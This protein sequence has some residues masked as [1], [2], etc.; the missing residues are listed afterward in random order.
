MSADGKRP[1][2]MSP[3]VAVGLVLV[4]AFSLIA[5]LV[6]S[7]YAPDLRSDTSGGANALSKSAI[8]FA[9]LRV[10]LENG[11]VPATLGRT[12]PP[13]DTFGLVI[14][15]PEIDTPQKDL[16]AL[17]QPGA[18]LIVLPKW[19]AANQPLHSGWV[20]KIGPWN[21]SELAQLMTPLV[22]HAK[23]RQSGKTAPVRLMPLYPRFGSIA[24]RTPV[25]IDSVQTIS[26]D[27]LD[28]DIVDGKGNAVLAQIK[29]TQ[30]YILAD[31]DLMNDHGLADVATA[32]FAYDLVQL[33]RVGDR[34]VSFDVTLNGFGQSPSLLRTVFS[35]PFLGA[36]LCAILAAAF[37]AFHAF[38]RFGG[39]VRPDRVFAFG[40]RALADNTAAV[41]RMM[42]REPAMAPRYA[43]AMLN[44]V[45]A[46]IGLPREK[47]TEPGWLHTLEK[48]S[49]LPY[50]FE[51]LNAEA[52]QVR[53]TGG[54][55]KVA[56]KLYKWRR[57]ILNE[58]R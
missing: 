29:G 36:T 16:A 48:R 33:L 43:Q 44:L 57:G 56:A 6:L 13:P 55:I 26:G 25:A 51:E 27:N 30:T 28:P 10:L 49:A 19:S 41:I 46:H 9:G 8:G 4:S 37:I 15:A 18:R 58:H 47:M 23:V 3:R 32:R 17:S 1:S 14:L 38:R 34:P 7:A 45:A 22:T 31:P 35:P 21:A 11:G 40:K 20:M 5:Y 54:L 42:R 2:F 53:D 50:R 12:P 52:A 24:P 39:A